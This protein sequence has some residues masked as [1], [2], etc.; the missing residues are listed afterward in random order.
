MTSTQRI[1]DPISFGF[2]WTDDGW[3]S[4]DSKA[5]HKA[6]RQARDKAAREFKAEGKSVKKFSLPG[7]LV[8]RGGIG[9]GKP[10]VEFVVTAYGVNVY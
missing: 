10:D 7:Q 1:F 2:I 5:A 8:R 3:Y 6:A 4:W 9:S